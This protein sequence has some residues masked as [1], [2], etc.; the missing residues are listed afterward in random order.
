VVR[1]GGRLR[2]ADRRVPAGEAHNP[3]AR[4][5]DPL[6]REHAGLSGATLGPPASAPR[7]RIEGRRAS[8]RPALR[9]VLGRAVRPGRRRAVRPG[10]GRSGRD[11]RGHV[12]RGHVPRGHVH[13]PTGLDRFRLDRVHR[14][15]PSRHAGRRMIGTATSPTAPT[16]R[17]GAVGSPRIVGHGARVRIGHSTEAVDRPGDRA[18]VP[19]LRALGE[20]RRD[21]T[22]SDTDRRVLM[23]IAPARLGRRDHRQVGHRSAQARRRASAPGL[24]NERDRASGPARPC[25]P[26]TC[27]VRTRSWSPAGGPSKRRSPLGARRSACSS[28]RS[29]GKHSRSSCSTPPACG[30]R[31]SSWRAVP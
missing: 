11:Q 3:A 17:A 25:Q 5:R 8:V 15:A 16:S 7:A 20:F 14:R 4:G 23:R 30:S 27:S 29:G 21:P 13:P 22:G 12:P 31:S 9:P 2:R 6:D 24:T 19:G 1:A 18:R 26:R 10:R 28:F